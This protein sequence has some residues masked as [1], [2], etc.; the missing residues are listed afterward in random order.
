MANDKLVFGS[1]LPGFSAPS[2]RLSIPPT[3]VTGP[4]G[5]S[6]FIYQ[7]WLNVDWDGAHM[8]YGLDRP[9]TAAQKFPLQKNLTPWER[10]DRHGGLNNARLNHNRAN[11]WSS[12]VVKTRGEALDLLTKFYSGWRSLDAAAQAN[13][14]AQFWDNRTQTPYGS[15]EDLPGNGKF[16]IVQLPEMGQPAPGYYVS[17]SQ[18]YVGAYSYAR[19][20]DQNL[21]WDAGVVPYSV[22]PRLPG[23]RK[24]D[25]GLVIRNSTGDSTEFFYGDTSGPNGTTQLGECSGFLWQ[26]LGEKESEDYSFIV[27]PGSGSGTAD[28][29]AL[30]RMDKVVKAQISKI[31]NTGNVLAQ[32][33][34]PRDPQLLHCRMALHEWG[35]PRPE[36]DK[37]LS[38]FP[39]E[40]GGPETRAEDFAED[41]AGR[42]RGKL[43]L[44]MT[45]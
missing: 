4:Y 13:A 12:I 34:A 29:D 7:C 45:P 39:R 43:A 35:G 41:L 21:Y 26:T 27:F 15:L 22:V 3:R 2:G 5:F 30:G 38:R 36:Y 20:W 1:P 19:E 9:D 18:A 37:E 24:G 6:A 17:P 31:A 42:P 28:G 8:C 25:F 40:H 10:P 44:A 16:P 32:R 33:L 23:V 11:R 14:L